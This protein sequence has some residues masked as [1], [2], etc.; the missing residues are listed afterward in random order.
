MCQGLHTNSSKPFNNQLGL[1]TSCPFHRSGKWY[2]GSWITWIKPLCG[3]GLRNGQEWGRLP[4]YCPPGAGLNRLVRRVW[5][6]GPFNVNCYGGVFFQHMLHLLLSW[7]PPVSSSAVCSEAVIVTWLFLEATEECKLVSFASS[8]SQAVPFVFSCCNS[9]LPR[10]VRLYLKDWQNSSVGKG[11]WCASLITW[12]H[13]WEPIYKGWRR[14]LLP[15]NCPLSSTHAHYC[16]IT[17]H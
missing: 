16:H 12:V 3:V 4:V 2:P 10:A 15:Q 11:A 9:S 17:T 6:S 5:I 8:W 13:S 14:G 7:L 1:L